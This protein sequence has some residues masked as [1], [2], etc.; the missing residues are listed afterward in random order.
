MLGVNYADL[1]RQV[2]LQEAAF[3]TLTKEDEAAK[4]EEAKE[5][6][7]VVV[8]DTPHIPKRKSF[9]PRLA[10][11]ALGTLFALLFAVIWV[12][13]HAGWQEMDP[14]DPR[15]ALAISIWSDVRHMMPWI[16]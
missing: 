13:V 16:R 11:T 8:L 5:T 15:K 7:V 10:I 2:D 9:P 4:V 1:L 3:E 12:M 14:S 6:P